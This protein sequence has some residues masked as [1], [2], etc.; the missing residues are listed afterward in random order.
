MSPLTLQD[1]E[2]AKTVLCGL[3]CHLFRGLREPKWKPESSFEREPWVRQYRGHS[4][5][6]QCGFYDFSVNRD[7]YLARFCEPMCTESRDGTDDELW[8]Q[9][10][11]Y[12]LIPPFL[13]WTKNWRVAVFFALSDWF[14]WTCRY[15]D[16]DDPDITTL[17]V[18]EKEK[19]NACVWA[20]SLTPSPFKQGEFHFIDAMPKTESF[21]KRQAAQKGVYT[22]ILTGRHFDVEEYLHAS[23]KAD[24]L[25]Q[26]LVP[27]ECA[28]RALRELYEKKIDYA[29]LYPD[30]EGWAKHSN[31]FTPVK[32][33]GENLEAMIA[34]V[35]KFR[36]RQAAVE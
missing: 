20:L 8:A 29:H 26:Y 2:E 12:G 34:R 24:N 5:P 25:T 17:K 15:D 16:G 6:I 7:N 1:W 21:R 35:T 4:Q 30:T 31:F 22:Q 14:G 11:H 23:A 10:R 33:F 32:D 19:P 9:G 36:A 13:D 3:D 18:R 28:V 27:G